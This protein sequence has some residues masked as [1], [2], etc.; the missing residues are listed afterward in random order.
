MIVNGTEANTLLSAQIAS[1]QRQPAQDT[2]AAAQRDRA[3][4]TSRI[5]EDRAAEAPQTASAVSAVET[6]E[7]GDP[8]EARPD[9]PRDAQADARD[10][11]ERT[12]GRPVARGGSVDLFV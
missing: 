1:T 4:E 10:A 3:L 2:A 9:L 11:Q 12:N 7:S 8:R 5:A 6:E